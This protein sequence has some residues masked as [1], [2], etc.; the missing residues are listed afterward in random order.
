[1]LK[2]E[3]REI[4][5]NAYSSGYE[6]GTIGQEWENNEPPEKAVLMDV[7]QILDTFDTWLE[8]KLGKHIEL[9]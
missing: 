9:D 4:I 8:E 6:A 5:A 3:L 2:D 1:M 7:W